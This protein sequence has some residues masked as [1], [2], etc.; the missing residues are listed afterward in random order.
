MELND[1]EDIGTDTSSEALVTASAN[2]QKLKASVKYLN[3]DVLN[4]KLPF[5]VDIIAS[6]PPYIGWDQFNTMSKN[7]V[8]YEPKVALFVDSEDPLL[9]YKA[10]AKKSQRVVNTGGSISC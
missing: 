2:A 3:H 10:I 6:N 1:I 9:F 4:S 5:S 8:D 7:V